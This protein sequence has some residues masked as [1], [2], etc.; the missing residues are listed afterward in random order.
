MKDT[1]TQSHGLTT[2]YKYKRDSSFGDLD[3]I[4][5]PFRTSQYHGV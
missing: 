5:M 1:R 2:T 4:S 3:D